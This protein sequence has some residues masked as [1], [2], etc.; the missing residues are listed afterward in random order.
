MSWRSAE[1]SVLDSNTES[2]PSMEHSSLRRFF[3]AGIPASWVSRRCFSSLR[4]RR[5]LVSR[6]SILQPPSPSNCSKWVWNFLLS[7]LKSL[8]FELILINYSNYIMPKRWVWK[9]LL[10]YKTYIWLFFNKTLKKCLEGGNGTYNWSMKFFENF[11]YKF[12]TLLYQSFGIW[13][14]LW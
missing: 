5:V 6:A 1:L 10:N 4:D 11:F 3:M 9:L 14:V 13:Y 12:L 2:S 8:R 7:Y